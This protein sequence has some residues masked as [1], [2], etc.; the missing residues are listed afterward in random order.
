M[1]RYRHRIDCGDV[2]ESPSGEFVLYDEVQAVLKI[3]ANAARSG[4]DAA[5]T[6]SNHQLETARR[7]KAESSPD[8]LESER[9]ANAKLTQELSLAEEGLANYQQEVQRLHKKMVEDMYTIQSQGD[10]IEHLRAYQQQM[11][12]ILK[13]N[14]RLR[15]LLTQAPIAKV[16]VQDKWPYPSVSVELYAP[17]LPPGEY[18]LYLM[19]D[20]PQTG[21]HQK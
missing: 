8:A 11:N 13:E 5:K 1:K 16:N 3:Q 20:V 14:E 9:Q 12:D 21:K 4:M 15:A 6:I 2:I 17:G 10:E 18:D 19:P 7:L